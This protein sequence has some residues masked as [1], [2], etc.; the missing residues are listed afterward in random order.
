M[1]AIDALP[2]DGSIAEDLPT[3]APEDIEE[4]ED[5][6]GPLG[7]AEDAEYSSVVFS[8]GSDDLEAKKSR[9]F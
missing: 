9:S 6:M 5:D 8:E 4:V 1:D 3:F 2:E 7:D